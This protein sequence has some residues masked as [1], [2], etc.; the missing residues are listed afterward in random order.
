VLTLPVLNKPESAVRVW[1]TPSSFSTVTVAPGFTEIELGLNAKFFMTIV[2]LGTEWAL[3]L[4]LEGVVV[5]PEEHAASV[6]AASRSKGTATQPP[7][8]DRSPVA[9]WFVIVVCCAL[10]IAGSSEPRLG[11]DDKNRELSCGDAMGIRAVDLLRSRYALRPS[12]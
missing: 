2:E 10:C 4:E 12:W 11:Q 5:D 6:T 7:I 9:P 3:C 1:V 8:D